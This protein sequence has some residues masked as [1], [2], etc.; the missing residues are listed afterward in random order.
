MRKKNPP[1]LK[2]RDFLKNSKHTHTGE[3]M[4]AKKREETQTGKNF[5]YKTAKIKKSSLAK[6]KDNKAFFSEKS[7]NIKLSRSLK[8]PPENKSDK[9]VDSSHQTKTDYEKKLKQALND[10]LYLRAEFENFKKKSA[11]EIRRLIRYSGDR[12]VASLANEV[13]D[14]LDRAQQFADQEKSFEKLKKG[15][16]MI[17]KKL[18]HV[19]SRFGVETLDPKGKA[20]D[21][22]YQEALNSVQNAEIPEGHV[23]ETFKKAYKMHDKVIRPAQVILSKGKAP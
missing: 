16:D 17:Q 12:I 20:F 23:A 15:L 4:K 10:N 14:D 1:F 13:L 9:A 8:K 2:S 5:G 18:S 7:Q 6:K 21:P 11:E 19:L 3:F 22:S